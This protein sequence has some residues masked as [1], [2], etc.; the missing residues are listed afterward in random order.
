MRAQFVLR[1]TH[2]TYTVRF[3]VIVSPTWGIVRHTEPGISQ[4]ET[5]A[6][7]GFALALRDAKVPMN[8]RVVDDPQ[9]G[10]VSTTFPLIFHEKEIFYYT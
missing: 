6:R 2:A 9:R 5:Y 4:I 1:I 10:E 8:D 7:N 3:P